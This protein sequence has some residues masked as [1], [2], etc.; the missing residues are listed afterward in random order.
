MGLCNAHD[1]GPCGSPRFTAEETEARKQYV[2]LPVSQLVS[3]R[4][5]TPCGWLQGQHPRLSWAGSAGSRTEQMPWSKGRVR[6]HAVRSPSQLPAPAPSVKADLLVGVGVWWGAAQGFGTRSGSP[7][8]LRWIKVLSD[9]CRPNRT[10]G[11]HHGNS[12][13]ALRQLHDPHMGRKPRK[14]AAPNPSAHLCAKM[15]SNRSLD[16]NG[17]SLTAPDTRQN[18]CPLPGTGLGVTNCGEAP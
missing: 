11:G 6:T 4:I 9:T 17:V 18:G 16:N 13:L 1:R 7:L 2:A 8:V 14:R 10:E 3:G 15:C 5:Q 12:L